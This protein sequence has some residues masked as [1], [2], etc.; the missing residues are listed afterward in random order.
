VS[1]L[2][3]S[4]RRSSALP[5]LPVLT[6]MVVA[7]VLA[8]DRTWV[9]EW[10][11]AVYQ[12]GFVTVLL[13]PLVAGVAAWDGARLARSRALLGTSDRTLGALVA[14]WVGT[15]TWVLAAYGVGLGLVA[16]MVVAS[17]TPGLPSPAAVAAVGPAALLLLAEAAAGLATGWWLRHPVAAPV[18]AIGCFLTTLWMYQSGPGELV[19]VGGATGSLV[20]LAPRASLEVRQELWFI[21]VGLGLLVAAAR[22]AGWGRRAGRWQLPAAATACVAA[23]VPLLGQGETFLVTRPEPQV[24][25]GSR[26]AVCVSPGYARRAVQTRTALLPYL[27][28]LSRI[29]APVSATFR[30]NVEPGQIT[31]GP[32]DERLI[33]GDSGTAGY[34]VLSAYVAKRCIDG[35]PRR[36]AAFDGLAYWL[37]ATVDGQR[38]LDP[39]VPPVVTGPASAAQQS[40]LLSAIE[41][42]HSC[43]P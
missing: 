22:L 21:V 40:W 41:T 11:W 9:H 13:G 26:P 3:T 15:A 27:D 12:F 31:V 30:Q 19:V 7:N 35:G 39:G 1:V 25:V 5:A 6:G 16:G 43:R 23:L 37:F 14:A 42:L 28:A 2:A 18:A 8:R 17:G 38:P 32:L 34:A 10:G 29:G 36:Q 24:C 4:V 33:L 20:N